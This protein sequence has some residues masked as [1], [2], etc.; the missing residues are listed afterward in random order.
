MGEATTTCRICED[1]VSF[2]EGWEL[3]EFPNGEGF[4]LCPD[5]LDIIQEQRKP[6]IIK[7]QK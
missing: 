2:K 1:E 7:N 5:C 4:N 3:F 6:N